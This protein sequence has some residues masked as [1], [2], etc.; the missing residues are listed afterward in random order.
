VTTAGRCSLELIVFL[1]FNRDLWNE[2]AVAQ[3]ML[4][5]E[6]TRKR[7]RQQSLADEAFL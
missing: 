1:R 7:T 4:R 2:V 5:V 3:T 6:Q